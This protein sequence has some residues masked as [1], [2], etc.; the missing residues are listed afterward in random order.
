VKDEDWGSSGDGFESRIF[1]SL[2]LDEWVG[3]NV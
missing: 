3:R 2:V 1:E